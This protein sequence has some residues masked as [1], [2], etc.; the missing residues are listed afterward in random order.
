MTHEL[1]PIKTEYLELERV[2]KAVQTLMIV[3]NTGY[4]DYPTLRDVLL[5]LKTRHK[6]L[7]ESIVS[8]AVMTR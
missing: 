2:E 4:I 3:N 8:Q 7:A 5:Y 6:T 1:E